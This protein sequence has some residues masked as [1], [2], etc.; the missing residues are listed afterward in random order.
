MSF[1]LSLWSPSLIMKVL[2][3]LVTV[4]GRAFYEGFPIRTN[5]DS[6][7]SLSCSENKSGFKTGKSQAS[8]NPVILMVNSVILPSFLLEHHMQKNHIL[9]IFIQVGTRYTCSKDWFERSHDSDGIKHRHVKP[10]A[11]GEVQLDKQKYRKVS[12]CKIFWAQWTSITYYPN[13]LFFG[14]MGELVGSFNFTL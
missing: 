5:F 9:Y 10:W 13:T 11:A 7:L 8:V 3:V 6:S 2:K 4:T 14:G 1:L 12:L